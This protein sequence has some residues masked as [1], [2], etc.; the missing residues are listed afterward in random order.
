MKSVQI[1]SFFWSVFSRIRTEYGKILRISPYSVRMRENM[2][3]K[4]S[5]LMLLNKMLLRGFG[6]SSLTVWAKFDKQNKRISAVI[7][8]M[9]STIKYNQVKFFQQNLLV[10]VIWFSVLRG[11]C[12]VKVVLWLGSVTSSLICVV[13]C[14]SLPEF[15]SSLCWFSLEIPRYSRIIFLEMQR[16][17][18][19]NKMS[20]LKQKLGL[21]GKRKCYLTKTTEK[22]CKTSHLGSQTR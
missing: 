12:T 10:Y 22:S 18:A 9:I 1:R 3:Q 6:D 4:N 20:I 5:R 15:Y 8:T 19:W 13:Q 7:K 11:S 16:C 17:T 21:L 14:F 2:D